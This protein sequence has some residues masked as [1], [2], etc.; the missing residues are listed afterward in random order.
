V[1]EEEGGGGGAREGEYRKKR[2]RGAGMVSR[3]MLLPT[4]FCF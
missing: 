1:E 2:P 3:C 4:A